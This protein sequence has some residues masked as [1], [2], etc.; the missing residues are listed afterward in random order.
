VGGELRIHASHLELRNMRLKDLELPGDASDVTFRNVRNSG[1]WMQGP[2]DIRFI[3]GEV[4]CGFCP[5]HSHLDDSGPPDYRPPTRIL[6]D[7]VFF[8]NWQA[9]SPDQHT[10]CLQ[11]LSGNGI[12]IRNSTFKNCATANGGRGA[13]ADLHI[14]YYG[15]GPLTRNVLLENNFFY[16]SGNAYAIQMDDYANVRLRYNSISGPIVIFDRAG[17]GT[18]MSFVGNVMRFSG[19]SAESSPV[20]IQW[21]YNVM[22]GGTCNRTDRNAPNGFIDPAQNLHL[23]R[24]AAAIGR[25]DPSLFPR[26]DI[27]GQR[28]PRG[29]RPDAGADERR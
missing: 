13:T 18:G 19:C 11:I 20:R 23:K 28:R 29:R 5:F 17:P 12:T 22:Q 26:R 6:F 25:G 16:P 27:D 4:A 1:V 2:T 10:E 7:H 9:A 3:G 14:S 24:S 21:R 8:H 15:N